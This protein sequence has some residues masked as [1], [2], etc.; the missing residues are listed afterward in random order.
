MS[1]DRAIEDYKAALLRW[2]EAKHH[3][4]AFHVDPEPTG[5]L[6]GNDWLASKI[7]DKTFADFESK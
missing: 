6:I 5:D 2:L 7:R 4:G 1:R 3:H